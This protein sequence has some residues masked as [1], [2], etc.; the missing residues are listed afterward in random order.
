LHGFMH[1]D[2]ILP[3]N[4]KVMPLIAPE[5]KLFLSGSCFADEMHQRA[6]Q[7]GWITAF[8]PHGISF[9]PISMVR[10]LERL[11]ANVPY[12]HSDLFSDHGI[13]HSFYHHSDFSGMDAEKV[14]AY[15]NQSFQYARESLMAAEVLIVTF[16]SAYHYVH[17]SI[18]ITVNN[19][20]KQ[21]ASVFEKRLATIEE[22]YSL[23]SAWLPHFRQLNP[24]CRVIFT[25]SP[26][27]HK[28]DGLVENNRSK[29]RLLELTHM[30]ADAFEYAEYFPAYEW[31]I[32]VLRD[33]RWYAIDRVHPSK[34]AA[35][36]IWAEF[37]GSHCT[38]AGLSY[39]QE[40]QEIRSRIAHRLRFPDS[41][42]GQLFL[43]RRD[44]DM[45][46]LINRYPHLSKTTAWRFSDQDP[47]FF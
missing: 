8:D 38:E 2:F 26:V 46:K 34:E 17:Q 3:F 20:H 31:L 27:R 11:C 23:W 32:D 5:S 47:S 18:G 16:G 44:E 43:H 9:N 40:M 19:C 33:Y 6:Q 22:M 41:K 30:L 12:T 25:V 28:K 39:L 37:M 45:K 29:A 7:H 14:L 35:D 10:G 42:A 1:T 24:N 13:V 36:Y 4:S 21:P 15:M